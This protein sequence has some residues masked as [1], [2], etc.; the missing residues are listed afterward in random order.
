[1]TAIELQKYC[2]F[3]T[4]IHSEIST[5]KIK[6]SHTHDA[7]IMRTGPNIFKYLSY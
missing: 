1:M 6:Q 7:L 4:L 5:A 3:L 2:P